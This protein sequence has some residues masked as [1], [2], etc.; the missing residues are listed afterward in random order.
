MILSNRSI[1]IS[2][3]STQYDRF[4]YAIY[5]RHGDLGWTYT[6]RNNINKR[7][8]VQ[9]YYRYRAHFRDLS[10]PQCPHPINHDILFYGGIL[11]QQYFV[12]M[13]VKW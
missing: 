2:S 3:N 4:G 13:C 1:N 7:I 10:G 5:H 12:D 6:L 9:D 8:S 11:H